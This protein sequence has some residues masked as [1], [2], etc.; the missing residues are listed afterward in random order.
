[1]ALDVS[2]LTAVGAGALSFLSPC[3]LPL[4]PPYLCYMA[5]VTVEDFR[6]DSPQA[7]LSPVRQALLMSSLA[8]VL[9]FTT[10][11]VLLGAGASTIGGFLRMWQQEIAIAAGIVIILMGLNFLGVFKLAFLS[12]E[13]RFQTQGK[14]A[15]PLSAY[16]MGLAFAFG[17]T[18]CI[19]PVLGPI[20]ALAGARD[21]VADGA[22]LLAVYSLGLGIPFIVAALFSGLFMRF[23][24]RFRMHLG[25]VEKVMG[26]LLV[27][28]GILFLTGGL[29]TFSFWLLETFPILGQLG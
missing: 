8:F 18:P 25:K 29:Q 13:A 7:R 22:I 5:G 28:T 14:P 27:A 20:L 6:S 10:V 26:G 16:V 15:N 24:A 21:T 12:R 23:L 11:F 17:W 2:Y 19:G 9:G 3:V 1:M 4:V